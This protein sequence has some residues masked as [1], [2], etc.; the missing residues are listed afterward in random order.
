MPGHKQVIAYPY[1]IIQESVSRAAGVLCS[2]LD[3]RYLPSIVSMS[4][5]MGRRRNEP[6]PGK[7]W[8]LRGRA[9]GTESYN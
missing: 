8:C 6:R 3:S 7:L 4:G 5:S 1:E 9:Y 2:P